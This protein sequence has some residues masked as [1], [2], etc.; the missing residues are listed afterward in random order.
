VQ[1]VDLDLPGCKAA[2]ATVDYGEG[3]TVPDETRALIESYRSDWRRFCDPNA[4]SGKPAMADLLRKARTIESQFSGIIDEFNK[5]HRDDASDL[6][7]P[8]DKASELLMKK[9]PAFVPAFAGSIWEYEYFRPTTEGFKQHA[10]LGTAEDKLFFDAG[11]P[12]EMDDQP[13]LQKTWDY[14]GCLLFGE[15]N[16][17]EML[18]KIVQ[19]KKSLHSD[20]YK[21]RVADLETS[22]LDAVSAESRDICTCMRK[23]AVLEDL[24][25]ILSYMRQEPTLSERVAP[26]RAIIDAVQSRKTTVS[27]EAEKHCSGG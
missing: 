26:V 10:Q 16:W 9:Y 18:D 11:I 22:L 15:F 1:T 25:R 21:K 14:G 27:S 20:V 17:T 5:A 23:E 12:I 3:L 7:A 4:Q 24:Q 6:R 8:T 2:S 19:L 13:W